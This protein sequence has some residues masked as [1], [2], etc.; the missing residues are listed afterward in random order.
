MTDPRKQET[1][2]IHSLMGL[3]GACRALGTDAARDAITAHC[4][5]GDGG[6]DTWETH[7]IDQ[8]GHAIQRA[9][10]I[11]EDDAT[12]CI[13]IEDAGRGQ[14]AHFSWVEDDQALSPAYA[15]AIHNAVRIAVGREPIRLTLPVNP[16]TPRQW[17]AA[18]HSGE[19]FRED[20]DYDGWILQ[21]ELRD[22]AEAETL[23][24][25]MQ[26]VWPMEDGE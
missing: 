23:A 11:A 3:I 6:D 22:E 18:E 16:E 14:R 7:L 20:D 21:I 26:A 24:R 10:E 15:A 19:C 13:T 1:R 9:G 17:S 25:H 8:I 5:L 4:D 12:R 2:L